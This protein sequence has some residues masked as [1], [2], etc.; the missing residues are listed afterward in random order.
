MPGLGDAEMERVRHLVGEHPVG[1]DHRR[2]VVDLTRDLEVVEVE[3]LEQLDLLDRCGDER[4]GLCPRCASSCR[5]S[6][7]EPAFAPMRIGMPFAFA[8]RHDLGR[9][10]GAADVAGVDPHGG[11]AGVDRL[12]REHALKWMSAM[13]GI[14]ERRT[15]CGSASASSFFGTATRTISQ[16]PRRARRSARSSPRRRASS[17]ASSTARRRERRRRWSPRRRVICR[18]LATRP[19]L[20]AASLRRRR[21]RG[22]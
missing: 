5:C 19:R 18:S 4:L 8:A 3:L 7:S 13:T 14:G 16:P 1:A 11:D 15:I 12:Q 17:S 2:H 22:R 10:V 9:L 21:S 20:A 6:G